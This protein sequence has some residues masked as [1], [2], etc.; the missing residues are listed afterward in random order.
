MILRL[1]TLFAAFLVTSNAFSQVK[2]GIYSIPEMPG[3]YAVHLSNGDLRRF[4]TFSTSGDWYKYEGSQVNQETIAALTNTEINEGIAIRISPTGFDGQT[5][6]CLP[7]THE[8]CDGIDLSE[9]TA[10]TTVLLSTGQLKAIFK[11]QWG[12][13]IVVFDSGGIAIILVFEKALGDDPYTA[14]GAYTATLGEELLISNI[15]T[16]VESDTAD[17]T[18]LVFDMKIS[19]LTNPQASFQNINCS[20]ADA[21]TCENFR[22]V[23]FSQLIRI[24]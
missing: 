5:K 16:V 24:F 20:I 15:T 11:S 22:K 17:S 7:S 1:I 10:G 3:F 4:Y 13:E 2:D 19:D 8:A 12:A 18:G 9:T 6:Y 23:Y 14:I 21:E